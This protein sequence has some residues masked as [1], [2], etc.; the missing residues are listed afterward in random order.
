MPE[1][2]DNSISTADKGQAGKDGLPAAG[3]KQVAAGTVI[4]NQPTGVKPI[5]KYF[6]FD[7]A[8]L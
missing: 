5:S 6:E 4:N 8:P 3:D 2:V 7:S 1:G